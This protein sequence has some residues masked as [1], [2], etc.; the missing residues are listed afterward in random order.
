MRLL[1]VT[2]KVDQNDAILGFFH[3]WLVEFAK[4]AERVIVICLWEG[5]HSLPDNVSVVSL[6]KESMRG[7]AIIK[8]VRYSARFVRYIVQMRDQYDRVFVHMNPEYIVL[9]G[10]FWRLT[11]K[12][13]A[14]WYTHRQVH[15]KLRVATLF[16]HTVLSA[17]GYSF[18][19]KSKKLKILGHGI[20]TET[21]ACSQ[22]SRND[23]FTIISVGRIAPIKNIDVL[24]EAA[25]TLKERW[26]QPFEVLLYGTPSD[27]NGERYQKKLEEMIVTYG[28]QDTVLFMGDVPNYAMPEKYCEADMVVNL[29]PTGGIDKA[30]LE[31]MASGRLVLASNKAF[32][33]HFD[34]Y[35]PRLIFRER[36]AKDLSEKIKA[37]V[38]SNDVSKMK[39][40]LLQRARDRFDVASLIQ[41]IVSSL[42]ESYV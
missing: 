20:D 13:I 39:Q 42:P 18:N 35:A 7:S 36:D 33:E 12:R 32:E 3:R 28:L 26:Q 15:F 4:H 24:I 37:L 16:A 5:E 34:E 2:Q 21:F 19:V 1:V 11:R 31:G 41:K 38:E 23:M 8:R 10:L 29:A 25:H 14:L 22:K 27:A 6:G 40:F 9:G 30:V 17:S